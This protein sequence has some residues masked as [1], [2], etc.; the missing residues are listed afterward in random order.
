MNIERTIEQG[1]KPSYSL[2]IGE[3]YKVTYLKEIS[4]YI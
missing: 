2:N 3:T 4:L 1:L